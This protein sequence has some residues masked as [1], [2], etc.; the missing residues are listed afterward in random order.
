[1]AER[2]IRKLQERMRCLLNDAGM[3]KGFW[4]EAMATAAYIINR[5]PTSAVPVCLRSDSFCPHTS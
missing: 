2:M 5:I 1:M 3:S 4:A